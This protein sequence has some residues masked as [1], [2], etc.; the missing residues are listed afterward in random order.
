MV[1]SNLARALA[2]E[3]RFYFDEEARD[4]IFKLIREAK[5][6]LYLVSPYSKHPQQL[7]ERLTEAIERGV[8][9]TIFYRD[10][11]DQREGV[12]YLEDLG[13]T[14]LPV[15]WLHSKIY[16]NEATALASSMNLLDS[17]FN[18]SSEFSVRIDKAHDDSLY[19]Q[20]AEYVDRLRRR[21]QR[22]GL[23]PA[24]EKATPAKVAAPKPA[25]TKT[26]AKS[27]PGLR[28]AR[29]AS[30]ASARGYCIRCRV[31]VPSNPE[32]PLC[33]DD[34]K[35]WNRFQNPDYDENYCHSCGKEHDTS[36]AKPL[37][38]RCWRTVAQA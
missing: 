22:R 27:A 10:E 28:S 32:K 16:I 38:R 29:K 25:P 30:A 21:A 2:A 9:V 26:T 20:L 14:V 6:S 12:T 37:C 3:C 34:Y 5:A 1:L 24:G 19:N 31:G 8:S 4:Q 23:L 33:A 36:M 15:E 35:S 17:S 18:N 13:A 11:K 7:R